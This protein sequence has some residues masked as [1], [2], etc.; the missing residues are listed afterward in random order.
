M[1]LLVVEDDTLL[2]QGLLLTEITQ[3]WALDGAEI[4]RRI[5]RLVRLLH[6]RSRELL[7]A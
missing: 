6:V 2:A 7:I 3:L 5:W 4:E 1:R